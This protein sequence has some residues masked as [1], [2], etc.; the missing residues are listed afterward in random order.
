V[1]VNVPATAP[2]PNVSVIKLEIKGALDVVDVFIRPGADG[3]IALS[4]RLVDLHNP[5]SGASARL[6]TQNGAAFVG[7]WLNSEAWVS[8]AF[9]KAKP[10]TYEVVAEVSGPDDSK[11]TLA[12]GK[13]TRPVFF[14]RP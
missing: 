5:Q 10:G 13:E 8:W 1:V 11:A 3:A 12:I 2:D 7:Y 6:E 9:T 14:A 4:A